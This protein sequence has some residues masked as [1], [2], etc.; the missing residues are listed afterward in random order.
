MFKNT[1]DIKFIQETSEGSFSAGCP[2]QSLLSSASP[3]WKIWG[4]SLEWGNSGERC[5]GRLMDMEWIWFTCSHIGEEPLSRVGVAVVSCLVAWSRVRYLG[6]KKAQLQY[7]E[8]HLLC[9][10]HCLCSWVSGI[11]FGEQSLQSSFGFRWGALE[12]GKNTSVIFGYWVI[13]SGKGCV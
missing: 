9:M 7:L 13:P 6:W 2:G 1:R 10:A 12:I 3:S 11:Q 4:Q 5:G 8:T